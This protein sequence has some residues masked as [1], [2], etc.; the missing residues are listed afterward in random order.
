M[1]C[2]VDGCG[3]WMNVDVGGMWEGWAQMAWMDVGGGFR[4]R[5]DECGVDEMNV[6]WM[7]GGGWRV[8]PCL[9]L[10]IASLGVFDRR[11]P[12]WCMG[13]MNWT[14]GRFLGMTARWWGCSIGRRAV[15][16]FTMLLVPLFGLVG[17]A[18]R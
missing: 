3:G 13:V 2:G 1:E 4:W 17:C 12:M 6:A 14:R 5:M 7:R 16:A 10:R 9:V 8:V 15:S 11:C 18:P